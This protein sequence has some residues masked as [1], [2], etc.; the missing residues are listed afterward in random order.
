MV[1]SDIGGASEIVRDG[2]DGA[3]FPAGDTP[4]FVEALAHFADPAIRAAAASAARSSV[5]E[6][7]SKDIMFARYS[8]L[9]DKLRGGAMLRITGGKR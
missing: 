4:A 3:L 2:I 8:S 7:Y 6:R 5:A 9:F 1:M